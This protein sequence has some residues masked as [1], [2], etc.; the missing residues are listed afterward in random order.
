MIQ[1]KYRRSNWSTLFILGCAVTSTSVA[2]ASTCAD[3]SNLWQAA[4]VSNLSDW[5][6]FDTSGRRL[7]HESGTLQGAELSASFRCSD[8]IFQAELTQLEGTRLYDGQ[9]SSGIPVTSQSAL[10]QSKGLLQT[11]LNVSDAWRLGVRLSGQT[12]WRDIASAGGA[13]G[14]PERFDWRLLSLGSQ[15]KTVLGRGQMTVA[16]WAGT[17]LTSS[18]TLNLPGRDQAILE[19]G[20]IRQVELAV[21]WRMPLGQAWSLQA[22]ARYSR[23][24]IEQGTD[25]VITRNGVPV[26][27]AHQPRTSIVDMP[28][29]IRINY[30][31]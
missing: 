19:L 29:A 4:Y 23:T 12:T 8:W 15:W 7:V 31:F 5:Q 3:R 18:M 10:R 22:D 17:Q 30:E 26:G 2:L 27:I 21:G 6:E 25:V 28:L 20:T 14:Y 16:A 11:S 24:D 13:S 1:G 9:T